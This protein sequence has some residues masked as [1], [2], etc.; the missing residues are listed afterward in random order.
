MNR[1]G[2]E[3]CEI[4]DEYKNGKKSIELS[5]YVGRSKSLRRQCEESVTLKASP[6]NH[7]FFASS[8][9]FI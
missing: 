5:L 7:F 3:R 8:I 9:S 4:K 6:M 1:D 2:F